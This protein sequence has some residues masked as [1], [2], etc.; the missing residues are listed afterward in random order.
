MS[1]ESEER[2]RLEIL[3]WQI[4]VKAMRK[5]IVTA[6]VHREKRGLGTELG[7]TPPFTGQGWG[8]STGNGWPARE[9]GK[10][11]RQECG[12][13]ESKKNI[14]EKGVLNRATCCLQF[15]ADEDGEVRAHNHWQPWQEQLWWNAKGESLTA[16]FKSLGIEGFKKFVM[17]YYQFTDEETA[18]KKSTTKTHEANDIS[19]LHI[20]NL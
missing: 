8:V 11:H 2:N 3:I 15:T 20:H 14:P 19:T 12:I 13:I 9:G 17:D 5:K 1:L 16:G 10:R 6:W 4:T 7:G 18:S